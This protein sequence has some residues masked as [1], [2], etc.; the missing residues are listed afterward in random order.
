MI[1]PSF[2]QKLAKRLGISEGAI[3][4]FSDFLSQW[5]PHEGGADKNN[6]TFNPLNTTQNANGA[7]AINSV[8]VRAYPSEDVGV[9]ATAQTLEN[10]YYPALLN[11]LK[12]GNYGDKANIA[13]NISTWGTGSFASQVA[14]GDPGA[15]GGTVTQ[16][17][18]DFA[19]PN[20]AADFAELRQQ[21]EETYK[22]WLAG[23]KPDSGPLWSAADDATQAY[24]GFVHDNGYPTAAS[25]AAGSKVL[26]DR[27]AA[28]D[29]E[30][31]QADSAFKKWYDKYSGAQTEATAD[32]NQR[33]DHNAANVNLVEARNKSQ[34]PGLM[35]RV[36][37]AGYIEQSRSQ[38]MDEYLKK[39]GISREAPTYQGSGI[40]APGGAGVSARPNYGNYPGNPDPAAANPGF[41]DMPSAPD[42]MGVRGGPITNDW[43]KKPSFMPATG[44]GGALPDTGGNVLDW[45]GNRAGDMT[46]VLGGAFGAAFLGAP[47]VSVGRNIAKGTKAVKHFWQRGYAQGGTN[48]PAGSAWVGEKGPETMEVPG[49]GS[50]TVGLNGPEQVQIPE[51]ANIT[52][53]N[54]QFA[55]HQI[56]TA[57]REGPQRDRMQQAMDQRARASDPQLREKVMAAMQKAMA[58]EMATNPPYTPMLPP[59]VKD[60]W[61]A[62]RQLSGTPATA[63]EA[64]MQQQAAGKGA[65]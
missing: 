46:D 21:K 54:E 26:T 8:G 49:F 18:G 59:G 58:S 41:I 48:I 16:P 53:V 44:R 24:F 20:Q 10:G 12:T 32:Y 47:G 6:A 52:P 60:Y 39:A 11:A 14:G 50:K 63:E 1:A 2:V 15:G 65:K 34:T 28:G 31:R 29:F 27:I 25:T 45:L 55:M 9:E 13:K 37:D 56:Q 3:P 51:G 7:T 4:A 33:A 23:G 5:Q 64:A 36:T 22:A 43:E 57:V 30:T 42:V 38:L 40:T 62:W 35:P 61:A 17:S 19:D